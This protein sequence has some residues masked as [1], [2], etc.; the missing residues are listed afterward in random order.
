MGR[1]DS[2]RALVTGAS[3][4]IGA[5][6]ALELAREGADVVISYRRKAVEA[7]AMVKRLQDAGAK[8]KAV[9]CEITDILAVENLFTEAEDF[10]GGID[11]V[12]ANAGIPSGADTLETIES[13]YWHK[14]VDTNLSGA[15][16]TLR[17]A[18]PCL[19]RAGGGSI[20]A[21]SSIAADLC[22]AGGGA[23]N[24]AK[25]GL[26]AIVM[27]LAREVAPERIRVNAIAPGLV[28]SDMGDM[29]LRIHGNALLQ[30]I[31]LG[32]IGTPREIGAMI[33]LLASDDG[34]WITGKIM[35][36][37]GGAV[38]QP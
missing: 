27:T 4:C 26:N 23:Y 2:K 10:L 13:R 31:P 28:E 5:G 37:D 3:R 18:V 9:Q 11:T 14:V 38:I 15:F 19:R 12:V 20:T 24:A 34:S 30:T 6:I 32:R 8:A 22:G 25:A 21:I 17:S 29:M 16:Y 33:A 1:L 35:R 7:L 36:I